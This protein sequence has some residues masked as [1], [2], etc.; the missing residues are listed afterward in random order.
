M[1]QPPGSWGQPNPNDPT[2][3]P[4]YQQPAYGQ[5]QQ[6]GY[7][8]N[9]GHPPPPGYP[10]PPASPQPPGYPPQAHRSVPQPSAT[11]DDTTWALVSHFGGAAGTL[12]G[13]FGWVGPL[14]AYTTKGTTSP[15]VR[16]HAVAALNFFIVISG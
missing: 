11:P 2:S 6:P 5:P 4:P 13:I 15:V 8:P 12:I 3:T 9:A 7:D 14:I 16:A 10:R 1:T